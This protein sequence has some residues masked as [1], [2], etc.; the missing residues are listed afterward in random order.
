MKII[1]KLKA[2]NE[3]IF[4]HRQPTIVCLG[5]SVTQGCFELESGTNP[6]FDPMSG[7]VEKMRAILLRHFPA[8]SPAI[9]N[10]GRSG[11]RA[12]GGLERLER[13]VLSFQPDLVTVCFGLNDATRGKDYLPTYSGALKEIFDR[14]QGYGAEL[15]FMTPNL[16]GTNPDMTGMDETTKKAISNIAESERR[17]DLEL[18]LEEAKKLCRERNIPVCDCHKK[19]KEMRDAGVDVHTLLSNQINHPTREMH[20]LFAEELVKTMFR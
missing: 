19:W 14:V 10:A 20:N 11:G 8:S 4:G 17:G 5:D 6:V 15:I 3:D 16:R 2:K 18:F 9:I 7:Y 12:D 1:D 13:D